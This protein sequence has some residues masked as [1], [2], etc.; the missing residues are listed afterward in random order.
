MEA[1]TVIETIVEDVMI[2]LPAGEADEP[3]PPLAREGYRVVLLKE[4]GGER[5][6][7]IWIG[8]QEG[9]LLAARLGEWPQGRPMGPDLT[10][11]LLEVGGERVVIES[12]REMTFYATVAV[13]A[14]SESHEVDAR[15]GLARRCSWQ[16]R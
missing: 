14:G 10:A 5:V 12:A 16:R 7:P 1:M 2:R 6:L 15:S 13:T 3:L 4:R 9:N 11:R 8:A